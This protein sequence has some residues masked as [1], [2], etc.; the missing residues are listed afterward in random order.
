MFR[1]FPFPR[2]RRPLYNFLSNEDGPTAV[3]YAVLLALI[4]AVCVSAIADLGGNASSTFAYTGTKVS[5]GSSGTANRGIRGH[6]A[7]PP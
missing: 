7:P 6:L 5:Q 3:E 1:R 4:I 2:F